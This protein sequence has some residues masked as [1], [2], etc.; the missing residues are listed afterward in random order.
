MYDF[1][2]FPERRG[3]RPE[4]FQKIPSEFWITDIAEGVPA[5]YA[6]AEGTDQF[7]LKVSSVFEDMHKKYGA[8]DASIEPKILFSADL[9]RRMKARGGQ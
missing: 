8:V 5:E 6:Q 1:T 4:Y 3:R 2:N 9:E 7:K